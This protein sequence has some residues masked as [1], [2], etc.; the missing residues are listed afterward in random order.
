MLFEGEKKQYTMDIHQ[1]LML[2]HVQ[3][4]ICLI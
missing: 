1:V 2:F 4:L 3:Y